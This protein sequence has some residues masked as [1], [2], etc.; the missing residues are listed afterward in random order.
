MLK[1]PNLYILIA[2]DINYSD[3]S[4]STLLCEII[5]HNNNIAL[6]NHWL[7]T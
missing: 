4:V 6:Y 7:M 1:N 2:L 5:C 3:T